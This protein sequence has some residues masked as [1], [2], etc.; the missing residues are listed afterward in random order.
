MERDDVQAGEPER[1]NPDEVG[2]DDLVEGTSL[3]E[4]A[5]ER[6]LRNRAAMGGLVIVVLMSLAAAFYEPISQ[7]G[8]HFTLQEQ[9]Q[10]IAPK[11]P[12][13]RSVPREYFELLDPGEGASFE[14]VDA[15]GDGKLDSRDIEQFYRRYEFEIVDRDG[16]GSL[17]YEEYVSAPLTRPLNAEAVP[18]CDQWERK[19][20]SS[21]PLEHPKIFECEAG[22]DRSMSFEEAGDVIALVSAWDASKTLLHLDQD[23]DG[24]ITKNEFRGMPAPETNWLGTDALGR[25]VLTRL[26]YGARI[27]LSVGLLAAIVSFIIGVTWGAVAGFAGGALDDVMMRIVDIMYGLPFMI[28]VILLMSVFGQSLLLLFVAIGAIRWLT[29]ARIVR[30]QVIS[31]K[32]EEFVEAARCVGVSNTGIVFKHLIPNALGPIIVY[33]TLLVPSVMLAEAFLSFLG[34][35]IQQPFTSWGLM[36]SEGRRVMGNAPWVILSAGGALAATLLSLNFLGDGL[37]DA[38]DPQVDE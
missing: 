24:V 35:G 29:M 25:D 20:A 21:P 13:A 33:T 1:P 28:L 30:G 36:A 26:V 18:S 32:E 9:H 23:S 19:E 5:F 17:D 7:Y 3:W 31:L 4:D 12:G 16:D 22:E 37:R 8:T 14:E 27:S 38:L 11:P 34:L 10:F 2:R 6:L 15:D